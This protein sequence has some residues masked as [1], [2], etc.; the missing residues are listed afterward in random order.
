MELKY[1]VNLRFEPKFETRCRPE[2]EK[3]GN[4]KMNSRFRP[5]SEIPDCLGSF[6]TL[7]NLDSILLIFIFLSACYSRPAQLLVTG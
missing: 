1:E 7:G 2:N 5:E 4:E 6:N 3:P